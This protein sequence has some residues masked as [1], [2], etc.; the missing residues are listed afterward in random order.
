M[1]RF[2]FIALSLFLPVLVLGMLEGGL[3][4]AGVE[5]SA[6]SPFVPVPSRPDARVLNPD[7]VARYFP[8]FIPAVAFT[9]LAAEKPDDVFRVVALGGSSTAGFPYQFYHGFPARLQERL[10][11]A[12]P[13]LRPEVVNLGLTAVNSYT[14]W[15]LRRPVVAQQ[16]DAVVIY[17]GHNEFYGALGVGS[18]VESFGDRVAL[19]RLALRLKRTA[20][21]AAFDGA[22]RGAAAPTSDDRTLMARMVGDATITRDS[23]AFAAVAGWGCRASGSP[24]ERR[25]EGR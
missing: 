2:V 6:R 9:P 4:F 16:P 3:H 24:V 23:D 19:K 8:A 1:K 10:A 7:Y 18:T 25:A 21:G 17:A 22:P 13:A 15:D 20:L 12:L 14:L 11:D 5:Q